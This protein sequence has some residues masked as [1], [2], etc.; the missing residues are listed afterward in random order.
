MAR[1]NGAGGAGGAGGSGDP[2]EEARRRSKEAEPDERSVKEIVETM[3][4]E[5]R[6]ESPLATGALPTVA[7]PN[8]SRIPLPPD[9]ENDQGRAAL[10]TPAKY[11]LSAAHT[12]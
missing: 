6:G 12:A 1:A 8:S 4:S 5:G 10:D 9:F 11:T 7:W 2:D 3:E